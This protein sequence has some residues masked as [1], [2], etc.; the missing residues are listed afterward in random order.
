MRLRTFA[1]VCALACASL[2]ADAD[3]ISYSL[4]GYFS[5]SL[6]GSTFTDDFGAFYLTGET[7]D[8]TSVAPGF[9]VNTGG[10]VTFLLFGYGPIA[11]PD[12]ALGAESEYNAAAF[13]DLQSGF[14]VGDYSDAINTY[15]LASAIGP[16]DGAFLSTGAIAEPT[17]LGDLS[18]T[19]ATGDVTFTAASAVVTPEPSSLLLLSTGL[20]GAAGIA[21]RHFT[22]A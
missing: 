2:A 18:I 8:V 21:R 5:G 4:S 1:T 22:R 3:P 11:F 12:T 17:S 6:G 14:A 15:D 9:Y 7:A 19:G 20:L 13:Y 16:V 10:S